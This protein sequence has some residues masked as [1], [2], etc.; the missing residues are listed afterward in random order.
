MF[1]Y[2]SPSSCHL[3]SRHLHLS[4]FP[5]IFRTIILCNSRKCCP[6][7]IPWSAAHPEFSYKPE[8]CRM[9]V[10]HKIIRCFRS[11]NTSSAN[12]HPSPWKPAPNTD[13]R[14]WPA[15]K[16]G[17]S[18]NPCSPKRTEPTLIWI[19]RQILWPWARPDPHNRSCAPSTISGFPHWTA[20]LGRRRRRE[21]AAYG[22]GP[23]VSS[24]WIS[25]LYYF[26]MSYYQKH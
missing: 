3:F 16:T 15:L 9:A 8:Q 10:R 21:W 2:S 12:P 14:F 18:A 23:R 13:P 5:P 17:T 20:F 6:K 1:S 22:A 7:W 19:L 25:S 26:R 4:I 24:W 11:T